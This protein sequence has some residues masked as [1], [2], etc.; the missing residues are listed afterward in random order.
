MKAEDLGA[1]RVGAEIQSIKP[2]MDNEINGLQKSIISFILAS[3]NSGTL[4]PDIA[5]TKWI[6]YV[7]YTKLGQ[8]LDQRIRVGQSLGEA[9]G[10][11]LDLNTK[12]G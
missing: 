11:R 12:L 2:Y 1:I 6:E 8:K 4:T 10:A 9:Q 3:V 7:S 5:Y